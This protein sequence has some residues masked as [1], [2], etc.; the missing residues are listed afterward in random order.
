MPWVIR[1]RPTGKRAEAGGQ[2]GLAG[3]LLSTSKSTAWPYLVWK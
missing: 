1:R 2:P 3:Q